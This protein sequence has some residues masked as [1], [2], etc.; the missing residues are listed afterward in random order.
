MGDAGEMGP[1]S[2]AHHAERGGTLR[3]VRGTKEVPVMT[4]SA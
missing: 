3:C 2:A 4:Q 1:G